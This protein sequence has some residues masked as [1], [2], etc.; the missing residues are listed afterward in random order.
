MLHGQVA[1]VEPA[2]RKGLVGGL[3][4]LEVALHDNVALEHDF[5]HG[6]A[7]LR[8]R[9]HGLGVEHA[10]VALQVV[11]HTLAGVEAGALANVQ[12][13]PGLMFGAHGGGAVHLGQSVH[14]GQVEPHLF[15]A[16][17]HRGRRRGARHHGLDACGHTYF[18]RGRGVDQKAVHD[19]R[20]AVV[21]NAMGADGIKD[22]LCV[23]P[24]QAHVDAS[25]RCDGPGKAPAVAMEH[26]QRPQVHRV[27]GH[28]P[29][30]HV[31]DGVG[32]GAPV[33]VDHALGV[34]GGAAGVVERNRIPLV[35]GQAPDKGGVAAGHKGVVVGAAQ[36]LHGGAVE[37]VLH[38]DHAQGRGGGAQGQ[39]L[40]QGAGEL[41]VHDHG[42]GLAVI[43]HEGDGLGVEPGVEGVEHG[44]R[45]G[46]AKVRLHHGR[47]VGQ[48]H[49]HGVVLADACLGQ[50]AGQLAAAG[51][52][53]GPGLAQRAVHD[54]Q[55]VGVDL[56]RAFDERQGRQ[57][58][59]VGFGAGQVLVKDGGHGS[60]QEDQAIR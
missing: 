31:A 7:V 15:H 34:A 11:A 12:G 37:R 36:A 42:L 18:H 51:V 2:A 5:A 59:K 16:L 56:G 13:I 48:H 9:Q 28:V 20:A 43:Q 45:H 23:H 44:A 60:V 1:A 19:G 22:G 53:L 57:G 46:N 27:F 24:A 30:Q 49:G 32:G 58:G 6:F 8:H 10:Y 17:D 39:R 3:G 40:G 35:G 55:T 21:R 38:L 25:T 41:R 14:V 4:V 29:L 52:G 54:G 33:V 26:G 47:G 50:R